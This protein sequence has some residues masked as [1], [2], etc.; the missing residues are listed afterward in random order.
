MRH[1]NTVSVLINAL[2]LSNKRHSTLFGRK[3]DKTPSKLALGRENIL[4]FAQIFSPDL[5]LWRPGAFIRLKRNGEQ[6][7]NINHLDNKNQ[8]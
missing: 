3:G 5:E 8:F 4:F 7:L 1:Q 2:S 6:N